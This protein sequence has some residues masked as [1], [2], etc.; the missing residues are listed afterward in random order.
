MAHDA[1]M[2]K[3]K[4]L[5]PYLSLLDNWQTRIHDVSKEGLFSARKIGSQ[6]SRESLQ[7]ARRRLFRARLQPTEIAAAILPARVCLMICRM[8]PAR[9]FARL[10]AGAKQQNEKV[11]PLMDANKR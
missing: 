1:K 6:P 9:A 11:Q 3:A 4:W 2:R 8:L 5:V 7:G 10:F